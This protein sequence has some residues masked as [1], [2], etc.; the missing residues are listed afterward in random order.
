VKPENIILSEKKTVAKG[1]IY[2]DSTFIKCP[3]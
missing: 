2:Y 1:H 3:E